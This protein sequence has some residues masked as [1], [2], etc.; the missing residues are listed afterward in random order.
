MSALTTR[1]EFIK[2]TVRLLMAG[3]LAL[4]AALLGSR[5]VFDRDCS[6]CPVN[7]ICREKTDCDKYRNRNKFRRGRA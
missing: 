6:L 5:I 2:K 7:G 3:I 4:I 1:N